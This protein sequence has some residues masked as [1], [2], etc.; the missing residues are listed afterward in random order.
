VK[1]EK[2]KGGT[3]TQR[4]H[5]RGASRCLPPRL[6]AKKAAVGTAS[7][8]CSVSGGRAKNVR[9]NARTSATS[10]YGKIPCPEGE[11]A[12]GGRNTSQSDKSMWG[13]PDLQETKGPRFKH[14]K[15]RCSGKRWEERNHL[16]APEGQKNLS[17]ETGTLGG[18]I[19]RQDD[20]TEERRKSGWGPEEASK[21]WLPIGKGSK[22]SGNQRW[23]CATSKKTCS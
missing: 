12:L 2:R 10:M 14:G 21:K 5:S 11:L 1:A 16:K 3:R 20:C 23:D 18:L 4:L 19:G 9:E 15:K 17:F 8:E 22:Q 6:R 13:F 7:K